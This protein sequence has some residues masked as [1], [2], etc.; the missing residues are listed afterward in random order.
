MKVNRRSSQ[1]QH[2]AIRLKQIASIGMILITIVG[3]MQI[4]ATPKS[5]SDLSH[6]LYPPADTV[7]TRVEAL[8]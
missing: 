7:H 2:K 6:T 5:E 4:F 8:P 3:L 1:K